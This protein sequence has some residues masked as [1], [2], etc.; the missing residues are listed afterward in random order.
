MRLIDPRTLAQKASLQ[1]SK[2]DLTK[3]SNPFTDLCGGTYFYLD[4]HD[5]AYVLTTDEYPPFRLGA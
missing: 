3:L 1:T 4:S 5:R 2:R